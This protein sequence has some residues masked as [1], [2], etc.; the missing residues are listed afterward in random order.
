MEG[1]DPARSGSTN[2][3]GVLSRYLRLVEIF[4]RFSEWSYAGGR[5]TEKLP[6]WDSSSEF[7]KLRRELREFHDALP[8]NLTF[9]EA[10]LSAHIEKRNATT[11]ASLHTLY[12][13]CKIML[14]REYIPFIALRCERPQGPLDEPT[15]PKDKFQVPEGFWEESANTIFKAAR[16]IVEL[17]RTCHDNNA[18]PESPQVGFAIWQAAFVCVYAAHF[19]H[20]DTR[21]YLHERH[22]AEQMNT[23]VKSS[24][25]DAFAVK[26]LKEMIPRLKMAGGYVKS[27][28]KMHDYYQGVKTDYYDRFKRKPLGW[29]G[30]GLEQYKMLEKELKEFGSL[31][32]PDKTTTDGSDMADQGGSR[33]SPNES[34]QGPSNGEQMQG[35]EAATP[36]NNG[37]WAAINTTSPPRDGPQGQGHQY[38]PSYQQPSSQNSNPPSLLSNGESTS[39]IN[40]PYQ[41]YQT[42]QLATSYPL[43]NQPTSGPLGLQPGADAYPE[44]DKN[45]AWI[46]WHESI[47]MA[48]SRFDNYAQDLPADGTFPWGGISQ[49]SP[50]FFEIVGPYSPTPASAAP[51]FA[52]T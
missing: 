48:N 29:I 7:F 12:S 18:L 33:A 10:N 34:G 37:A 15:F 17:V 26:L 4:G 2:D 6:P 42:Q 40:S 35:V 32:D 24:Y 8:S 43:H 20:M 22:E 19:E 46:T 3:D 47:S 14:H 9:T 52:L 44:A 30:G 28:R 39:S 5:R 38:G 11:Y 27:L 50:N 45:E 49:S 1:D 31:E 23:I 16:D 36:R 13:L 51:G 21:C 41:A 25:Y